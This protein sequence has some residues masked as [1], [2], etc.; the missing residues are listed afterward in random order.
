MNLTHYLDVAIHS[1]LRDGYAL[2]SVLSALHSV[3][4]QLGKI[5]DSYTL[6]ISFPFWI[7][8]KFH[9]T[10]MMGFGST[11]PV[12]RVLAADIKSLNLLIEDRRVL[13]MQSITEISISKVAPIPANCI[14]GYAFMRASD[15]ESF[16]PSQQRRL[17][18]RAAQRDSGAKTKPESSR[19]LKPPHV[20]YLKVPLKSKSTEQTFYRPVRRIEYLPLKSTVVCFDS[21]G[22][23]KPNC[24]LPRF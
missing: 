21:W 24:A 6:G 3:N 10:K 1:D 13:A 9:A 16:G 19:P 8:P 14:D 11:G 18:R 2:E 5:G 22:F 7:D 17:A 20:G 4:R 12:V 23:S 15:G